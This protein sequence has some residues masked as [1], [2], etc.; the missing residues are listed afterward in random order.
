MA[1]VSIWFGV[2]FILL[3]VYGFVATG[4]IHYT[5]LIP[6]ALGVLLAVFG[7]LAQS[8]DAK[9]RKLYMHIA[10]TVGLLG[11][12]GTAKSLFDFVQMQQGK[13]F[14]YPAAVEAKSAM[15]V[16]SLVFVLLCVRSFISAR[17]AG[18]V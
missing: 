15:A 3:G 12:L 6:C 11:F 16:L 10:V 5:A 14:P 2:L 9:K 17:R 18:V 4:S 8:P 1:K 7:F 13:Y